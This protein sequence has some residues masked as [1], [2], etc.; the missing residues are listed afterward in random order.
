MTIEAVITA[1]DDSQ[2]LLKANGFLSVDGKVI[3]QMHDFSVRLRR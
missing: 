1:V 3:Y 2:C